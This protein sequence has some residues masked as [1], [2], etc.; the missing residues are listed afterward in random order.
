M[1]KGF[2]SLRNKQTS[3]GAQLSSY[4]KHTEG[5]FLKSKAQVCEADHSPPFSAKPKDAWSYTTILHFA[6]MAVHRDNFTF[7]FM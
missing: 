7:I 5:S 4:L 6:F 2:S 1:A 3:S